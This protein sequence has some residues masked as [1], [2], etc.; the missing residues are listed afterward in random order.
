VVGHSTC[1]VIYN[2]SARGDQSASLTNLFTQ[3]NELPHLFSKWE[4]FARGSVLFSGAQELSHKGGI[5]LDDTGGGKACIYIQ[6]IKKGVC[7][8]NFAI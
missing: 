1:P 7:T 5:Q 2:I 6:Q 4:K 8:L 3:K